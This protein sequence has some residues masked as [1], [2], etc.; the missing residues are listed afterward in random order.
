[1]RIGYPCI[2]RRIGCTANHTFRLASYSRSR[3]I[4]TIS[5]NLACLGNILRF[6]V[7]N[8]L[9]F[10]RISSDL[11]PFASHPLCR[12][13]WAGHF[14]K[15]LRGIGSF[16]K[17]HG[18]RISMHPDQFVLI[19]STSP[20]IVERSIAELDYHAKVLDTMGLGPDAKVQIHAGGVYG[21][22]DAAIERFVASYKELSAGLKER[23]VVEN[24]DRLYSLGDCLR[25]SKRTGI[26]VLFDSFHHECLNNGEEMREAVLKARNTW[27]KKDGCLMI[28]YSQQEKKKRLGSHA[29]SIDIRRFRAFLNVISGI[30]ADIMLEIKDKEK[31]ALKAVKEL[32]SLPA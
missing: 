5:K 27:G 1:M 30:K 17:E 12:F 15:D 11:V 29:E 26:P 24:D 25:I 19:N 2:N 31:S 7:D 16:I 4:D 20:D 8:G 18:I 6:N 22:K 32:S 9:L 10:F 3:L 13:D 28:D 14:E 21:D 23:L